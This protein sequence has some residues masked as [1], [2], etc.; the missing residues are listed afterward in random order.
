MGGSAAA[1]DPNTFIQAQLPHQQAR[2]PQQAN[3]QGQAM[4]VNPNSQMQAAH[5][6]PGMM[7]PLANDP[8]Q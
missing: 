7:G 6:M 2:P 8:T 1:T 3:T 5:K 4:Q